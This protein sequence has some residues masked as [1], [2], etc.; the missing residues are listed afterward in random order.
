MLSYWK[1]CEQSCLLLRGLC[2]PPQSTS[3]YPH[4]L[5][6]AVPGWPTVC[7]PLR[8]DGPTSRVLRGESLNTG[9]FPSSTYSG[10][11]FERRG[12]TVRKAAPF[13]SIVSPYDILRLGGGGSAT[14]VGP[15]ALQTSV[16]RELCLSQTK[17]FWHLVMFVARNSAPFAC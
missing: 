9:K 8:P 13:P 6:S 4:P 1:H 3:A 10:G 16:F 15:V 2:L 5:P 12:H 14:V 11:S 7:D 17:S